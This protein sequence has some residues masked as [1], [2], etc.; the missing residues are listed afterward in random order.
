MISIQKYKINEIT[1]LLFILTAYY[2]FNKKE[3]KSSYITSKFWLGTSPDIVKVLVPLQIL[4]GIGGVFWYLSLLNNPPKKGLLS[5]NFL[6][7]KMYDILVLLFLIGSIMW[8]LSLLQ[9]DLIEKKTLTK[10]LL[11]CLGLFIAAFAGLLAQAGS[12]EADN[13]SPL[14]I[15]VI[16][17]PLGKYSTVSL[18]I[19]FSVSFVAGQQID[20]TSETEKRLFKLSW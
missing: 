17:A 13:I 7:N 10:S 6:N 2:V 20:K 8:P 16:T 15:L 18:F 11:C 5:Y 12:F 1:F 14:A 3:N 4:A 19:I 9:P